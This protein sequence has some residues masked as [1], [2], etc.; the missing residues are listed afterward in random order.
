MTEM[1]DWRKLELNHREH[2]KDL[3]GEVDRARLVREALAGRERHRGVFLRAMIWLGQRLAAW[4]RLPL[5]AASEGSVPPLPVV[6]PPS[7]RSRTR[8]A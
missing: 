1:A 4:R 3:L 7:E 2:Y 5:R 6:N 8:Q